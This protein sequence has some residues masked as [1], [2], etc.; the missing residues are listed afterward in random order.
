MRVQQLL[1][2]KWVHR[3]AEPTRFA[4]PGA[5]LF[6]LGERGTTLVEVLIAALIAS[7]TVAAGMDLLI[8]QNK[9]HVIQ[10]GIAEMQHNGRVTAEELVEKI[11]Q[12]GYQ[13]P[14]G[15]PAI[16]A[17]NSDP[18]TIAVAFLVEPLCTASLSDPMPQPSSE[19]KLKDSDVSCFED[20]TWAYIHDP[21]TNT[22]EF[23]LITHVQVSAGMI[24]HNTMSLSKKYDAGSNVFRLEFYKYY[25]DQS[26]TTR[27]L[28]MMAH[29][30]KD[31]VIYA[32]NIKDL[33]FTYTM[34]DGSTRDTIALARYVRQVNIQVVAQ[35]AN[36]DLF[37]GDIRRDTLATSV[38]VRNLDLGG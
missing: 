25:V 27:P 33:Q 28:F 1:T 38:Q 19:L 35:T 23:F 14:E 10:E 13:L 2:S 7:I 16:Y 22:G 11:R 20:D 36:K 18:D 24:Q 29:N 4:R 30:G 17:W 34:T 12:A 31:P 37:V 3:T 9:N 15:L 5:K 6:G 8:N 21:L 26:D 32:D